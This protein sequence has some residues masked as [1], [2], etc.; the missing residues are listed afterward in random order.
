MHECLSIHRC[1]CRKS[2]TPVITCFRGAESNDIKN[3]VLIYFCL[4]ARVRALRVG[5]SGDRWLAAQLHQSPSGVCVMFQPL[6]LSS[7]ARLSAGSKWVA[8]LPCRSI[9]RSQLCDS[10]G[11][12][13]LSALFGGRGR[14]P[15]RS[16]GRVRW[17]APRA[18]SRWPDQLGGP[19]H[20][21]LS[22]RPA[23][24]EG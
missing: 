20:P 16:D 2:L 12:K 5:T 15:S 6:P 10:R 9:K 23:G 1:R 13:P 14:R 7:P 19:P 21:A 4:R 22:P 18:R 8:P 24:G 17:A 3:L 11:E